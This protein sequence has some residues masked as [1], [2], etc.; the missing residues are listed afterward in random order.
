LTTTFNSHWR[1][2]R[3]EHRIRLVILWRIYVEFVKTARGTSANRCSGEGRSLPMRSTNISQRVDQQGRV[4]INCNHINDETIQKLYLAQL[5]QLL[6]FDL[7][8][9]PFVSHCLS[10]DRQQH[11]PQRSP[12]SYISQQFN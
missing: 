8:P 10:R 6:E 3:P 1:E 12:H 5:S 9:G 4:P 11:S 2:S 7:D